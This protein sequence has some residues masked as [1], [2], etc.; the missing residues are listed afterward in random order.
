MTA[1]GLRLGMIRASAE[2]EY[3]ERRAK[4]DGFL[5]AQEVAGWHLSAMQRCSWYR[6][7]LTNHEMRGTPIPEREPW[8][9]LAEPTAEGLAAQAGSGGNPQPPT[10]PQTAP[11]KKGEGED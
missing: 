2:M 4:G 3:W 6:R 9:P 11:P 5:T 8:H 10:N 7:H 1:K